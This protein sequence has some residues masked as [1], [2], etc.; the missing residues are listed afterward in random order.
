M[1]ETVK[2]SALI[3]TLAIVAALIVAAH[4][5]QGHIDVVKPGPSLMARNNS[6]G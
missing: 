1:N 3:V 6:H 4:G 2:N 5:A